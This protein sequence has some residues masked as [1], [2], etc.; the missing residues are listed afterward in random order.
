MRIATYNVNSLRARMDHVRRFTEEASPDVLCLQE[1]KLAEDQIPWEDLR[2][3]GYPHV[4]ARGQPTYNG[5]AMLSKHPIDDPSTSFRGDDDPQA[6]VVA[7]TVEGV[8]IYGLYVPNGQSVGSDKFLY[9]LDWLRR[10][11]QEVRNYPADQPML[12]CG[13]FNIAPTDLDV[14]DPFKFDG[15]VHAHPDERAALQRVLDWGLTDA[16]REVNPFEQQFTWWDYQKMGFVRNH[17]LRIDHVFLSKD[18]L[19]RLKTVTIHRD[20][21]GWDTPSDHAPVSVDV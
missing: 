17:G 8:R 9:K 2:E 1:L 11:D 15:S 19:G 18:L 5:V 6:R 7:G 12:V 3:L 4:I 21:R 10:L 14:W 16:W 20:V 13:D